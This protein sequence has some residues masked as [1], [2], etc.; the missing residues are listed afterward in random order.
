[1][2]LHVRV[3]LIYAKRLVHNSFF[4]IAFK[5][6]TI[7]DTSTKCCKEYIGTVTEKKSHI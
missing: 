6:V 2:V 7:V 4:L 1:M 5:K 3:T